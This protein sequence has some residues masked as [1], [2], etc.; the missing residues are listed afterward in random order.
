MITRTWSVPSIDG[1][2]YSQWFA[3]RVAATIQLL[4][5]DWGGKCE[6]HGALPLELL[7]PEET[8]EKIH[9]TKGP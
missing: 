8:T 4:I 9:V 7:R 1:Q 2:T 3:G 5:V 6:E